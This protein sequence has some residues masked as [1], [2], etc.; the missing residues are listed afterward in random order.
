METYKIEVQEF[1]ARVVK[2]E[3]N[4]IIDAISIIE[5]KYKKTEIVLDYNDFVEVNFVDINSQSKDD[6]KGKIVNEII[7]YLF[8][9]EKKHFEEFITEPENHIYKKLLRLRELNS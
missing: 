2:I 8:E 7:D 1:L 9:K 3:A 4:S 6:E 5:E